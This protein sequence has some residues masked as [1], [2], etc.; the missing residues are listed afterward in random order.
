MNKE[1]LCPICGGTGE[2]R[3]G[4]EIA[5]ACCGVVLHIIGKER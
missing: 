3:N 1:I 5:C 2:V 4:N